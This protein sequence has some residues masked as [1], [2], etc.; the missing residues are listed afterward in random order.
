[1]DGSD[2]TRFGRA[3]TPTGFEMACVLFYANRCSTN[4]RI[5]D[6]ASS[7]SVRVAKVKVTIRHRRQ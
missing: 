2:F 5:A 1:M 4:A 3:I 6:D 7:S